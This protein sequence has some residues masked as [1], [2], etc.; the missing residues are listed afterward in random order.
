MN[1]ALVQVE[2]FLVTLASAPVGGRGPE[3]VPRRSCNHEML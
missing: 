3:I 1:E 2:L